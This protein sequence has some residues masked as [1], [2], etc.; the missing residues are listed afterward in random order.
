VLLKPAGGQKAT[1]KV[2]CWQCSSS[3][4]HRQLHLRQFI[5]RQHRQIWL[6]LN[7]MKPAEQGVVSAA[8]SSC[9]TS[10]YQGAAFLSAGGREVSP[11][12]A[13]S[14]HLAVSTL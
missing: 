9:T 12:Q 6:R 2:V 5:L 4:R 10:K 3:T 7:L 1:R 11:P 14:T 13:Q 8:S